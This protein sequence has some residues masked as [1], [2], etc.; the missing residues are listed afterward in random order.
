[1]QNQSFLQ[2]THLLNGEDVNVSGRKGRGSGGVARKSEAGSWRGMRLVMNYRASTCVSMR[3]EH[4]LLPGEE[5]SSFSYL[6][7][8]EP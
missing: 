1:M 7:E 6:R 5:S 3:P 8:K 4:R 2:V